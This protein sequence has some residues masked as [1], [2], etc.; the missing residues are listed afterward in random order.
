M[1]KTTPKFHYSPDIELKS[2]PL[3]ET[4]LTIQW[5]LEQIQSNPPMA[6]DP[7]FNFTF[8]NRFYE[9]VKDRFGYLV[10]LDAV[11]IPIE[12]TP[13]KPRYQFR[14]GGQDDWPLL[15]LGPGV[16]S[17]NFTEPYTW[18][19]FKAEAL[20]LRSTLIAAYDGQELK[21]HLA[22]LRYRNAVPYEYSSSDLLEFLREKLNINIQT[23]THIPGH[24]AAEDRPSEINFNL[25]Y[26]LGAPKG[27]GILRVVTGT[28]SVVDEATSQTTHVEHLLF[29]LEVVSTEDD[30]PP[31]SEE[32]EFDNWL[33]SA[34]DLTHEWFF[35]LIDGELLMKYKSGEE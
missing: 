25:V 6:R 15:Q 11:K 19:Q 22:S 12:I 24:V 20:Y 31:L 18:R 17:V 10:E 32:A 5:Q 26:N 13:H 1:N 29:D 14:S 4:W 35:S 16:A 3:V 2:S 9:S 23:P 8:V 30:T 7:G 27:K 21:T 33:T 28:K 34:H